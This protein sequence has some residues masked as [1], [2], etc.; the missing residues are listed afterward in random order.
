MQNSLQAFRCLGSHSFTIEIFLNARGKIMDYEELLMEKTA[1]YYY[2]ENMTQQKIS[3]LLGIS[4]MRVIQLLNKARK[5]GVVQ[6]KI[7]H[8]S[9]RRME[10]ERDLIDV[11]GLN[12]AFVVPTNPIPENNNETV[13]KAA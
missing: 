9:A 8:D 5:D 3:E 2:L 10:T 4:R 6:F 11:F 7:R 12:D 13:A 1:W